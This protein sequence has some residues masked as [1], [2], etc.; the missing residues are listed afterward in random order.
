MFDTRGGGAE[1]L[2]VIQDNFLYQH[3]NRATRG[4][5][6]LDLVLSSERGL[7]DNLRIVSLIGRSDHAT[8]LF[9]LPLVVNNKEGVNKGFD[10]RRAD[11][12]KFSADLLNVD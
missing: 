7:V 2:D 11:Y 5:N 12:G 10:Y 6:I 1:F 8:I 3:V 4:E 9:D